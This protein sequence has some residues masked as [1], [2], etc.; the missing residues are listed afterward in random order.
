MTYD[1]FEGW[2]AVTNASKN[3]WTIDQ[4]T[5]LNRGVILMYRGGEKGRYIQIEKNGDTQLGT[6]EGAIPHIG[7]ASFKVD[8]TVAPD[9]DQSYVMHNLDKVAVNDMHM[10]HVQRYYR[11]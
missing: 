5:F 11:G 4:V 6:Y 10:Y 7:E 8:W 3:R 2:Q 1:E 9:G